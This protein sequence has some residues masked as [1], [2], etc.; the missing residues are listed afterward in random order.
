MRTVLFGAALSAIPDSV[1]DIVQY[2]APKLIRLYHEADRQGGRN[3]YGLA[4]QYPD[5]RVMV[6][7]HERADLGSDIYDNETGRVIRELAS[8]Q[9]RAGF[10]RA[11]FVIPGKGLAA[12]EIMVAP[13]SPGPIGQA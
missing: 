3:L 11:V 2:A 1:R 5:G 4:V 12:T 10:L 9:A 8:S 7:I 6:T 13:L